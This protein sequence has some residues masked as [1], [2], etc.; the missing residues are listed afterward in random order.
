[1]TGLAF[2]VRLA[3]ALSFTLLT[4]S[5]GGDPAFCDGFKGATR[6]TH[7][8]ASR[9]CVQVRV[10]S[11]VGMRQV[12]LELGPRFERDTGHTLVMSFDSAGEIHSRIDRGE[13]VD[14]VFAPR[15][16]IDALAGGGMILPG[17]VTDL[18]V[19]HVGV[20]VREDARRPDITTP[21]AF[22][23]AMLE[24]KSIACP[25]PARGGSSG[26][27]IARMFERLGIA[28]Q[29]QHK[30]VY[31][32][33]PGDAGTMPGHAVAS[34]RAEVALHQMQELVAVPGVDIVGPLPGDLQA[35]FVFS[36]GV[37]SKAVHR[38]AAQ[39]LVAYLRTRGARAV[40]EAKGMAPASR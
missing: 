2:N 7:R 25:D 4:P 24:A 21:E 32:S 3:V 14:L 23:R 10:L 15:A 34:G 1:M 5:H 13:I 35:A 26:V 20:A 9:T 16:T 31:S 37:H 18:A 22:K 27:H 36:A 33:T 17:S 39:A 8:I 6:H 28:K 19:S 40:I 12:L 30:L 29:V 38:Q 11:A